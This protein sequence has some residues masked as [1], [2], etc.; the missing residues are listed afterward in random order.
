[1]RTGGYCNTVRI[2]GYGNVRTGDYGNAVRTRGYGN[3]VRTGV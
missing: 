2:G 3:P 1:M